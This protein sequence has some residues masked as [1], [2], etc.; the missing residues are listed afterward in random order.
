LEKAAPLTTEE[1]ATLP[2]GSTSLTAGF[3]QQNDVAPGNTD[4]TS[5]CASAICMDRPAE[6][7]TAANARV[8]QLGVK[9]HF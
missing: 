6:I 4:R 3:E 9:F 1:R 8:I 7:L 2:V 5:R